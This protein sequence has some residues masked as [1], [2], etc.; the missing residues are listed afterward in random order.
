MGYGQ[1]RKKRP[2]EDELIPI[3]Q[4]LLSKANVV[5]FADIVTLDALCGFPLDAYQEDPDLT[6]EQNEEAGILL[7][8]RKFS[9]Q[10]FMSAL[11]QMSR[12]TLRDDDVINPNE[13][14]KAARLVLLQG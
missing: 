6:P 8:N 9:T 11:E 3:T 4:F 5:T 2:G 14:E 13:V 7:G 1:I 10:Q 12:M